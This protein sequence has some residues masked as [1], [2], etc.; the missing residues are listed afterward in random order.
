[1]SPALNGSSALLLFERGN[2]VEIHN[3]IMFDFYPGLPHL[4]Y[5]DLHVHP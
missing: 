1:M 2:V 4:V 3:G 5:K